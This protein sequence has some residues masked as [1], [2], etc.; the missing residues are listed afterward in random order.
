MSPAPLRSSCRAP[1]SRDTEF[2][3]RQAYHDQGVVVVSTFDPRL[4][5]DQRE[6]LKQIADRF[7]G[8]RSPRA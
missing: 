3:K 4:T 2:I 1:N 7:Y 5:W 6:L 8:K